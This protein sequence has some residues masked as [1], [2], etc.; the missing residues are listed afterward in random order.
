MEVWE[1]F[2]WHQKESEQVVEKE[3]VDRLYFETRGQPGL[4]C[5]FGELLTQGWG[6]VVVDKNKP[7]TLDFFIQAYIDAT[8]VLPNNNILNIIS[9]ANQPE[10]KPFVL[11][12]FQTTEKIVF[13][14]NHVDQNFLYMN[15]VIDNEMTDGEGKDRQNY[16]KFAN[17]FVQTILFG[18]FS[19]ELF[20]DMRGLSDPMADIEAVISE[21]FININT[22]LD[23]Y[24]TYLQANKG[25]LLK[26]VPR[27]SDLQV[28]E[29][30]FHFNL[31]MYLSKLIPREIA[32]VLPEFPTGNGKIDLL[33]RT[34]SKT[35]GLELK[36]FKN[37]Y[38]YNTAI[39]QAA[40]YGK[41]LNL[42]EIT[43]VFFIHKID[44]TNRQ[45]LETP[46][47]D[48]KSHVCVKPI[49]IETGE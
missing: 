14:F 16:V 31:Y 37:R 10:H 42:T 25:W 35:Y 36:S 23:W 8:Q 1:M 48:K 38:Y 11:D 46:H 6:D 13:K 29:A 44:D 4:T 32:Q 2:K 18:H 3:A 24:Q 43:L 9:K 7:I 5:W 47:A 17:P 45:K 30:V 15:G 40:Q 34:E 33:I 27:R 49:F 26:D 39:T 41:R 20:S 21:S 28:H 22:I 12:L 19:D